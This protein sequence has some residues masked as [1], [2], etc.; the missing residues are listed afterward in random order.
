MTLHRKSI[1]WPAFDPLSEDSLR[2]EAR[3]ILD[4][5]YLIPATLPKAWE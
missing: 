2:K 1:A 3:D 4:I 5:Q